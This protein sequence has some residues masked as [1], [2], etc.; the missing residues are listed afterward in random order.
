VHV[1]V[2]NGLTRDLDVH[3]TQDPL[4]YKDASMVQLSFETAS[5]ARSFREAFVK[6][7]IE[8]PKVDNGGGSLSAPE[9]LLK[10][11][12]QRSA[13]KKEV[14]EKNR[15]RQTETGNL[16]RERGVGA[17]TQGSRAAKNQ[18]QCSGGHRRD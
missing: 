12:Q 15:R 13:G 2:E 8:L 10:A 4:R 17:I 9:R 3:L 1:S 7:G 16:H 18:L 14:L 6:N 5:H 11:V